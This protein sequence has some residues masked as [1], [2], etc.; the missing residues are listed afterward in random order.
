MPGPMSAP[1]GNA[2]I[3]YDKEARKK[4]G[5]TGKT[6]VQRENGKAGK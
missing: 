4:A 3:T 6:E 5:R 1:N 2:Q